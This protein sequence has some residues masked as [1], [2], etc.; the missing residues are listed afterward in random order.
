MKGPNGE[1]LVKVATWYND[2]TPHGKL[3]VHRRPW[4]HYIANLGWMLLTAV[5]VFAV[6]C[7]YG[8]IR[9]G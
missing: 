2:G 1:E 4:R 9:P 8:V 6:L 7:I 5:V 3:V